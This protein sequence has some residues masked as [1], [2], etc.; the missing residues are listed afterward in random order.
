MLSTFDVITA[1]RAC[2]VMVTSIKTKPQASTKHKCPVEFGA[3]H[4]SVYVTFYNYVPISQKKILMIFQLHDKQW[5]VMYTTLLEQ[6]NTFA[7]LRT[8]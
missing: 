3:P 2:I 4:S 8:G 5:K 1:H 6:I 7:V